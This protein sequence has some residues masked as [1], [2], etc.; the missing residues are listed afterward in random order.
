MIMIISHIPCRSSQ[1]VGNKTLS[2]SADSVF[3]PDPRTIKDTNLDGLKSSAR[4]ME[5][6]GQP[7]FTVR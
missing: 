3:T 7:A 6:L 4:S 2:M 1:V 5:H